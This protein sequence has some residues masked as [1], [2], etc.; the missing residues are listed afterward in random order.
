MTS[1]IQMTPYSLEN[2]EN[3][4]NANNKSKLLSML[5]EEN[6]WI[7]KDNNQL[8][9]SIMYFK[10]GNETEFIK[11]EFNNNNIY[12]SVPLKNSSFQYRSKFNN[13]L[14]AIEY[15]ETMFKYFNDISY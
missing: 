8:S 7:L 5:F 14:T 13:Y 12:V 9:N 10:P 11:F 3:N 2:I 1:I 6:G 4:N 15:T